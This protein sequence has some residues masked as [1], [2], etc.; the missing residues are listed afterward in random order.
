MLTVEEKYESVKNNGVYDKDTFT[1]DKFKAIESFTIHV[2]D[3]S[4]ANIDYLP[5]NLRALTIEVVGSCGIINIDIDHHN[6]RHIVVV[7]GLVDMLRLDVKSAPRFKMVHT[8]DNGKIRQIDSGSHCLTD[9]YIDCPDFRKDPFQHLNLSTLENLGL[10]G[11]W[12]KL[13]LDKYT[14]P[15]LETFE[16]EVGGTDVLENFNLDAPGVCEMNL[17]VPG[18]TFDEKFQYEGGLKINTNRFSIKKWDNLSGLCSLKVDTGYADIEIPDDMQYLQDVE[19]NASQGTVIFGDNNEY[20]RTLKL[21]GH[22]DVKLPIEAPILFDLDV[23]QCRV[24][25]LPRFTP[26]LESIGIT[27]S[28]NELEVDLSKCDELRG[29]KLMLSSNS[30]FILPKKIDKLV[31]LSLSSPSTAMN[32]LDIPNSAPNLISITIDMPWLRR[33]M[34]PEDSINITNLSI[35]APMVTSIGMPLSYRKL[36]MVEVPA[37]AINRIWR[38]VAPTF[39]PAAAASTTSEQ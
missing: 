10:Y 35:N 20:L 23:R 24:L 11:L 19:I 38:P 27:T 18:I 5:P 17:M 29:I 26:N 33:V 4:Q 9:I 30:S 34:L 22:F 31:R 39:P 13:P 37:Q 12:G 6:L 32:Q 3:E 1:L 21:N 14:F 16:L 15:K 7:G 25:R 8:D 2:N 36:D 28:T